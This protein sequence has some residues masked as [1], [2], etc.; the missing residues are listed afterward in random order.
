MLPPTMTQASFADEGAKRAK[1]RQFS[2]VNGPERFAPLWHP[3]R[4]GQRSRTIPPHLG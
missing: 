3:Y 2:G 1:K 4:Y